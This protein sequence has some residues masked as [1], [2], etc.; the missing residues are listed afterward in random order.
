MRVWMGRRR[1][2]GTIEAYAIS[3]TT[4]SI[5]AGTPHP[6]YLGGAVL[7]RVPT[8]KNLQYMHEN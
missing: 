4:F 7:M 1:G 5:F 6:S 2:L 8:L 3:R